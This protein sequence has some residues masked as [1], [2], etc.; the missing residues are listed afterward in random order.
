MAKL[1]NAAD[2]GSFRIGGD[3]P[4][5][6]LGFGAMRV[7]GPGIWGPPADPAAARATLA[8]LREL[9]VNFIDTAESYGP[10]SSEMLLRDVLYPYGDIVIATK[11]GIVR[12]GPNKWLPHGHPDFLR[13]GVATSLLRLGLQRLDLWQLHRIDQQVPR[14]DQFRVIRAMRD[15]GLIRH[16]G[17]SEVTIGEIRAA[18]QFFPVATIQ[19]KYHPGEHKSE[20]ELEFCAEHNIGFIPWYPLGGGAV[21]GA[22]SRLAEI[23]RA[24]QVTPSAIALAWLLQR[25]PVMLPI[26]GT[27]KLAHLEEN[28]AAVNVR[29]SAAEMAEIGA[30]RD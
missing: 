15:E 7:T 30:L 23:A 5:H 9:G 18:Q 19:N 4:V 8:R 25:A 28:M 29:L 6:R 1:P 2:A 14:D 10:H 27:S 11:G 26:P 3:L 24:H 13:A 12:H 16:V 21:A 20:A 17:L 22:D